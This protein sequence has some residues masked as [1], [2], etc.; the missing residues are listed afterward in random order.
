MLP[1]IMVDESA[2]WISQKPFFA[3]SLWPEKRKPEYLGWRFSPPIKMTT[4]LTN[5]MTKTGTLIS[6]ANGNTSGDFRCIF[7]AG[8]SFCTLSFL[9]PH[10]LPGEAGT[11][12]NTGR[13]AGQ[14]TARKTPASSDGQPGPTR[15][16]PNGENGKAS[17]DCTASTT[18][19]VHKISAPLSKA[20]AHH[21]QARPSGEPLKM[22]SIH[23]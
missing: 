20:S 4:L 19:Q 8:W 9:A 7:K 5:G 15:H 22:T 14:R 18:S 12:G 3:Q 1:G 10:C 2:Y 17:C 13:F 23:C 21:H 16:P 11:S 6:S